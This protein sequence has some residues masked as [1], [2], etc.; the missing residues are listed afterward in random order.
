MPHGRKIVANGGG[1]GLVNTVDAQFF[2]AF[3]IG[4]RQMRMIDIE[5]IETLICS[6]C[7]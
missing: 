4:V 7:P 6:E 5:F 2:A 1:S 3:K